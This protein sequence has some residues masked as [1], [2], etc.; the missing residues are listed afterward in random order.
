VQIASWEEVAINL[1]G[2]W[3]VKV[4]GQ[5]VEFNALAC[6]NMASNL[7]ELICIN[8]KTAKHLCDK[9]TQSCVVDTLAL[10][11]VYMT[12]EVNSSDRI[13]NGY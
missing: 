6:I 9:F 2:P 11:D 1:I 7:V 13:F 3:K 10:Y 4:N 8:N 12:R 5:Q